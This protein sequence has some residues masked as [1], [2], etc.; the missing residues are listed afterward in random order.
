MSKE[1][2]LGRCAVCG[3][4]CELT[5]EHVPP[6]S[7]FNDWPAR[8]YTLDQWWLFSQGE[9]SRYEHKQRGSGY[10]SICAQCNNE[11][12]GQW[13]VPEFLR[14]VKGGAIGIQRH[15]ADIEKARDEQLAATLSL[16]VRNAAPALF[17]KQVAMMFLAINEPTFGDDFPELREFVLDR[18]LTGLPSRYRVFLHIHYNLFSLHVGRTPMMNLQAPRVGIA[19]EILYSPF[20]YTLTID[21]T[22]T[23]REG[24]ISGFA[25]LSADTRRDTKVVLPVNDPYLPDFTDI[26]DLIG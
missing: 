4:H 23:E 1:P 20:G 24:E 11:R 14:W 17:L 5:F 16:T 10:T 22:H 13:Y 21:D 3:D 6:E 25:G 2:V 26:G 12:G 8:I 9:K 18:E 19:S 15:A 7:A